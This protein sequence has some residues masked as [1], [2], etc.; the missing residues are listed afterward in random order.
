MCP[1]YRKVRG[2]AGG[3][4]GYSYLFLDLL[5]DDSIPFRE[6]AIGQRTQSIG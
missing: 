3:G 5:I 6:L 4:V 1:T 2:E